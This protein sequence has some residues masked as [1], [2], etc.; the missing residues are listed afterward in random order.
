MEA[1]HGERLGKTYLERRLEAD[2]THGV[3]LRKKLLGRADDADE[4]A[5]A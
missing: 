5:F 3:G 2:G 1:A 4:L